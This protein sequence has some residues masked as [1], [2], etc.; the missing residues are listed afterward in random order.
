MCLVLP[1]MHLR[2]G[3]QRLLQSATLQT[4]SLPRHDVTEGMSTGVEYACKTIE[5]RLDVPNL[6]AVKQQQHLNNI[7]REVAILVRSGVWF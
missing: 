2:T 5:K 3:A 6:P 7:K 1:S 4:G